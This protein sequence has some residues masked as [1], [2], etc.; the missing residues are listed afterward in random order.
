MF[1]GR[2]GGEGDG[3]LGPDIGLGLGQVVLF[4]FAVINL[5]GE[6]LG[7]EATHLNIE[8]LVGRHQLGHLLELHLDPAHR[9]DFPLEVRLEDVVGGEVARIHQEGEAFGGLVVFAQVLGALLEDE[10]ADIGRPDAFFVEGLQGGV[11][12]LEG[13]VIDGNDAERPDQHIISRG[14]GGL[15]DLSADVGERFLVQVA[16]DVLP[17]HREGGGV[18]GVGTAARGGEEGRRG[19]PR[20]EVQPAECFLR[21]S[22]E[23]GQRLGVAPTLASSLGGVGHALVLAEA[24]LV[25]RPFQ[26]QRRVEPDVGAVGLGRLALGLEE[27]VEGGEDAVVALLRRGL[28]AQERLPIRPRRRA[29]HRQKQAKDKPSH[30]NLLTALV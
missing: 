28:V 11:A 30:R 2:E 17:E 9:L 10:G 1:A 29:E 27:P 8:G 3:R 5:D 18:V 25:L 15:Q 23:E 24:E 19:R 7:V 14:L 20:I 6:A 16:E 13:Q 12:L 26:H 21:T 4:P 22:L